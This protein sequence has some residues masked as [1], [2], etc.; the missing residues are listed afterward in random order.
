MFGAP[1][2]IAVAEVTKPK[3]AARGSARDVREADERAARRA[4]RHARALG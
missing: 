1:F 4:A 2:A 3:R